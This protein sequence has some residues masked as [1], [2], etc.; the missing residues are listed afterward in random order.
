MAVVSAAMACSAASRWFLRM[1]STPA[2]SFRKQ[3]GYS[4][5]SYDSLTLHN[6]VQVVRLHAL[7]DIGPDGLGLQQLLVHLSRHSGV[8]VHP[9]LPNPANLQ[10][11]TLWVVTHRFHRA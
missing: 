9:R 8:A 4:I 3:H 2:A 7:V 11:T 1:P 6:L 10:P 5:R